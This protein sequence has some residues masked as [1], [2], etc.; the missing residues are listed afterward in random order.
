M[1]TTLQR[2]SLLALDW[3]TSSLRAYVLDA[4]GHTLAERQ[5]PW[6]LMQVANVTGC[7]G[8]EAFNAAFDMIL[9]GWPDLPM[10]L[11]VIAAGMV[12]SAQGWQEVPY[13]EVPCGLEQLAANLVAVH[14]TSGRTVW[15]VPGLREAGTLPNV[16]RGEETQIMGALA[17]LSASTRATSSNTVKTLLGL[18]G[19]HSKWAMLEDKKLVHF[20]TFMT[21][22][23]FSALGN[24]TI[25]ARTSS[26]SLPADKRSGTDGDDGI[27]GTGEA[28]KDAAFQRGVVTALSPASKGVLAT[29]FSCRTLSLSGELSPVQQREYL[30]GLL[31]GAEIAGM[32]DVLKDVIGEAKIGEDGEMDSGSGDLHI[33]LIGDPQLC[34]RYVLAL[35]LAGVGTNTPLPLIENASPQ[36]LWQLARMAGLENLQ[37]SNFEAETKTC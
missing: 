34:K 19:S 5:E 30:S 8:A 25:L 24:H 18:P 16:M 32:R 17:Q 2:A 29:I 20:D 15:I 14:A 27:D 31:I 13:L 33:A 35:R 36:G 11:P 21:G 12:G 26:A 7:Q 37:S 9:S 10:S 4:E 3:G 22:E 6:G 28:S 1:T 23:A